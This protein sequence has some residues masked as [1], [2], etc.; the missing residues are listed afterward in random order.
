MKANQPETAHTKTR[1]VALLI[2]APACTLLTALV[3]YLILSPLM[4]S[5]L[6]RHVGPDGSGYS[7]TVMIM[8]A[9]IA[10]AVIPFA[11]GAAL[12]RG[13]FRVGHWFHIQKAMVVCFLSLGYGIVGVALATS[14]SAVGLDQDEA[15]GNSVAM[16]LLGFL[17]L[18]TAAACIYTLLLPRAGQ[19][20]LPSEYS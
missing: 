14:V 10:A 8:A 4:P 9:I 17:L 1:A 2:A 5:H 12:A 3:L 7:S 11:I 19:E 20:P 16:G 13:F 6:V 15:S 18:F